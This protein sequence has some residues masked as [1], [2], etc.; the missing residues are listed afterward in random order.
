MTMMVVVVVM[1]ASVY[2]CGMCV[3]LWKG[4]YCSIH[5]EVRGQLSGVGSLLLP[6]ASGKKHRSS[7]LHVYAFPFEHP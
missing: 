4:A 6:C 5:V 1:C 3:E 7:G 2:V